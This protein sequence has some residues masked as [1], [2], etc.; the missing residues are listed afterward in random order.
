[1]VDSADPERF[2]IARAEL[3]NLLGYEELENIPFLVLG[4]KI[5]IAGAVGED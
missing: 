2:H 3:H 4:N 5:D 1:M